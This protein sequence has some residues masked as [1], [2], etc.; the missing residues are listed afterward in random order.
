MKMN[1]VQANGGIGINAGYNAKIEGY[2]T[3]MSYMKELA[4]IL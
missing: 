3:R 1:Q 2:T 4:A